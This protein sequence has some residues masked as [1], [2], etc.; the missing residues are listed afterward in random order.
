MVTS[1]Y[2]SLYIPALEPHAPGSIPPI[3]YPAPSITMLSAPTIKPCPAGQNIFPVNAQFATTVSPQS[4]SAIP[5]P[6]SFALAVPTAAI[7]NNAAIA[8]VNITFFAFIF[9]FFTSQSFFEKKA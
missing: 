8:K 2:P 7:K 3:V 1:S 5:I 9:F 4:Q 6:H